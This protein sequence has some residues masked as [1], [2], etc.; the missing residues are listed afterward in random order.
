MSIA[1]FLKRKLSFVQRVL[2]KVVSW[3]YADGIA[4]HWQFMAYSTFLVDSLGLDLPCLFT[5]EA[6]LV[7]LNVLVDR[8]ITLSGVCLYS[9]VGSSASQ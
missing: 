2:G 9:W 7:F 3:R 8:P 6:P 5:I 4:S 1:R